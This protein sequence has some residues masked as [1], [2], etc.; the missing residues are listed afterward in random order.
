MQK[1][2]QRLQIECQRRYDME[3]ESLKRLVEG[4]LGIERASIAAELQSTFAQE[5][6]RLNQQFELTASLRQEEYQQKKRIMGTST[7]LCPIVGVFFARCAYGS[8]S[9]TCRIG[10]DF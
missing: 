10:P 3:A 6:A 9:V 8:C 7:I 5:G 4:T 1:V 2:E